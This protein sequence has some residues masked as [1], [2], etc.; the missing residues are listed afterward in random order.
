[1]NSDVYF[2]D[3]EDLDSDS[4]YDSDAEDYNEVDSDYNPDFDPDPESE[5]CLN[6]QNRMK[7]PTLARSV[8]RNYISDRAAADLATS[9]IFDFV[10]HFKLDIPESSFIIDKSKIRREVDKLIKKATN[11]GFSD[12]EIWG[13]YFDGKRDNT[14]VN[15]KDEKSNTYHIRKEN[16]EHITIVKEP[17]SKFITYVTAEAGDAMTVSSSILKKLEEKNIPLHTLVAVGADGTNVNTG[18]WLFY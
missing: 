14:I 3:D 13:L 11:V 12:N 4:Y 10:A 2:G 9:A 18:I 1:M 5:N 15:N 7:L 6:K 17:T 8:Q 16:Q